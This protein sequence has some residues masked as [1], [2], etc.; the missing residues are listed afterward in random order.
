M[1]ERKNHTKLETALSLLQDDDAEEIRKFS[2]SLSRLSSEEKEQK[3]ER[4]RDRLLKAQS[5]LH[6]VSAVYQIPFGTVPQSSQ[7]WEDFNKAV[8]SSAADRSLKCVLAVS[9]KWGVDVAK[10]YAFFSKG[11]KYCD[12]LRTAANKVPNWKLAA[13]LLNYW[14]FQRINGGGR[15]PPVK[16]DINPIEQSDL[17]NLQST[18]SNADDA[19][20]V[21]FYNSVSDGSTSNGFCLDKYGL[22]VREHFAAKTP[23]LIAP[24]TGPTSPLAA[25]SNSH[26]STSNCMATGQSAVPSSPSGELP[27]HDSFSDTSS[28]ITSL[29]P[30]QSSSSCCQQDSQSSQLANT[31]PQSPWAISRPPTQELSEDYAVQRKLAVS[32]LSPSLHDSSKLIIPG[33]NDPV[34]YPI[35]TPTDP[36]STSQLSSQARDTARDRNVTPTPS[37]QGPPSPSSHITTTLEAMDFV[38]ESLS[39]LRHTFA[40]GLTANETSPQ[41]SS[42]LVEISKKQSISV[43]A[44]SPTPLS[45]SSISRRLLPSSPLT[46]SRNSEPSLSPPGDF[47]HEA[48]SNMVEPPEVAYSEDDTAIKEE[49]SQTATVA[50]SSPIEVTNNPT[51]SPSTDP[52]P[53]LSPPSLSPRS[54]FHHEA[55]QT[56]TATSNCRVNGAVNHAMPPCFPT[57]PENFKS[58]SELVRKRPRSNSHESSPKKQKGNDGDPTTALFTPLRPLSAAASG[59]HR[60]DSHATINSTESTESIPSSPTLTANPWLKDA[61]LSLDRLDQNKWLNDAIINAYIH[62]L[63]RRYEFCFLNSHL[64]QSR[65]SDRKA[66]YGDPL[67]SDLVLMPIHMC[68]HWYLLVMYKLSG[69]G[70]T[71]CFLD[72]LKSPSRSYEHTFTLWTQY[73]KDIGYRGEVH[74]RNVKIPQQ[75][76]NADCGVFHLAFAYQIVE[77]RQKFI[78]AVENGAGVDW[79]IDALKWRELVRLELTSANDNS[80]VINTAAEKIINVE[81]DDDTCVEVVSVCHALTSS[82]DRDPATGH[83]VTAHARRDDFD[84]AKIACPTAHNSIIAR[85]LSPSPPHLRPSLSSW[86]ADT[87]SSISLTLPPSQ[88]TYKSAI[89][90]FGQSVEMGDAGTDADRDANDEKMLDG[91]TLVARPLEA[92]F[93]SFHPSVIAVSTSS[94]SSRPEVIRL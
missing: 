71:V 56:L 19:D 34:E 94:Q 46:K 89:G 85:T 20:F 15:T 4:A 3:C 11:R 40:P 9:K 86:P 29:P 45:S 87:E 25:L 8:S 62:I 76:N 41:L 1:P 32:S 12:L 37:G 54:S 33:N 42:S 21:K 57:K 27:S 59:S 6:L 39:S 17:T 26:T 82:M 79:T 58:S 48:K 64:L 51:R 67:E 91:S 55:T 73:L 88:P 93:S 10:H 53:A 80:A 44:I 49:L 7:A 66:E 31:T 36:R 13:R 77:D 92:A 78:D 2:Q 16:N 28:L 63:A 65:S 69:T 70:Y 50:F 90:R 75:S 35:T 83:D 61:M 74:Q 24:Q 22:L 81:S 5:N 43:P 84:I 60:L 68:S 14:I 52:N 72:S 30:S 23:N 18:A 38:T 47:S